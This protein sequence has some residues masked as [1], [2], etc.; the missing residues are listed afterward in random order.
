MYLSAH[1]AEI[2]LS[3][4][5]WIN[6]SPNN[7]KTSVI[8]VSNEK[9]YKTIIPRPR[10]GGECFWRQSQKKNLRA[11]VWKIQLK[12]QTEIFELVCELARAAIVENGLAKKAH[13]N[14][15]GTL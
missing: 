15:L 4:R 14:K 10:V 9:V 1:H 7:A 2:E 13:R 5:P 12:L 11:P 8:T 6:N 3:P